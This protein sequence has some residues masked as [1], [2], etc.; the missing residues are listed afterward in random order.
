MHS[1]LS[2]FWGLKS[3]SKKQKPHLSWFNLD[4]DACMC[5]HTHTDTHH[6]LAAEIHDNIM[7]I[8]IKSCFED[9]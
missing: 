1:I 3:K 8:S 6:S 9:R 7:N 4:T 2:P 5:T